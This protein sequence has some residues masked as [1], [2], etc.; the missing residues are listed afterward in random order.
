MK[1]FFKIKRKGPPKPPRQPIRLEKPAD[2]R[3]EVDVAPDGGQNLS[4][5]G[6]G[7][8]R[9]NL[10]ILPDEGGRMGTQVVPQ[11]T[12]NGDQELPASGASTS[13]VATSGACYRNQ[14]ASE[15]SWSLR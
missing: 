2:I 4:C 8:D 13:G 10:T 5:N 3:A 11:D 6:P 12:I 15:C 14:L 1:R 7:A 9:T